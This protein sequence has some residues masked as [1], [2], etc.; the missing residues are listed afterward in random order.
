MATI[1]IPTQLRRYCGG[2]AELRFASADVRTA[3]GEM[4]K[5]HPALYRCI[6]DEAG[7]VRRHVNVFVNQ[8]NIRDRDGPDT[9]LAEKDVVM[10][11]PAVS[12]G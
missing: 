10:I 1:R 4:E 9:P 3:L 7:S 12:G 8:D 11:L 2:L 6:C 5:R